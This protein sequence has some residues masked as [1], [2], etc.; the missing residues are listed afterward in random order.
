MQKGGLTVYYLSRAGSGDQ[1]EPDWQPFPPGL[2]MTSGSPTRRS[3]SGT[4]KEKAI[5]YAWFVIF[6]LFFITMV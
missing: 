5:S 2:R 6:F 1:A 4:V 3:Y